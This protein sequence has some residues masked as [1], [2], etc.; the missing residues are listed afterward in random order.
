MF[1]LNMIL[2]VLIA[3]VSAWATGGVTGGDLFFTRTGHISVAY[4]AVFAGILTVGMAI[5]RAWAQRRRP[6]HHPPR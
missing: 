4:L 3:Y 6:R 2:G 1:A 5:R